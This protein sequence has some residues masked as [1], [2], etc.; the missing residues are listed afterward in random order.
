MDITHE[1]IADVG[2]SK[3][4]YWVL[5]LENQ[6]L[7]HISETDHSPFDELAVSMPGGQAS[8]TIL[9]EPMVHLSVDSFPNGLSL[10]GAEMNANG[11]EQLAL[12]IAKRLNK[13]V[14]VSSNVVDDRL[15]RP[16]ME[17]RLVEE[18]QLHPE[19]F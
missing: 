15:S 10:P 8:T 14:F 11:S 4:K 13:Q 12:K 17:K 1:F 9:G 19:F 3:F 5:R 7:I 18:I 6:L 16:L 2:T